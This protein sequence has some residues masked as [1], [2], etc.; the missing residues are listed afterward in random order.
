[1]VTTALAKA[2][3]NDRWGGRH[4]TTL[5]GGTKTEI[6][7]LTIPTSPMN[8]MSCRMRSCR[9]RSCRTSCLMSRM[10]STMSRNWRSRNWM[11]RPNYRHGLLL[12]RRPSAST[13]ARTMTRRSRR[14]ARVDVSRSPEQGVRPRRGPPRRRGAPKRQKSAQT[15]WCVNVRGKINVERQRQAG[16]EERKQ[17]GA[18]R[19]LGA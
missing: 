3:A 17:P 1:M 15:A 16:P 7:V 12:R 4:D 2:D 5:K 10:S 9:M 8:L 13:T 14:A 11:S 18:R 19:Y 6:K